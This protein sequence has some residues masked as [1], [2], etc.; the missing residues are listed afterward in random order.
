[1]AIIYN[2]TFKN[3]DS[4]HFKEIPLYGDN[5]T[6]EKYLEEMDLGSLVS[7]TSGGNRFSNDFGHTY[8]KYLSGV[9]YTDYWLNTGVTHEWRTEFGYL[10]IVETITTA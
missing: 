10:P 9:T 6:V 1:M 7:F 8:N 5:D 3:P 4:I 2:P